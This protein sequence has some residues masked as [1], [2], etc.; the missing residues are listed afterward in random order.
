MRKLL[1]AVSLYQIVSSLISLVIFERAVIGFFST[2]QLNWI[3]YL[4]TLALIVAGIFIIYSN[5]LL[6]TSCTKS[7]RLIRWNK[8]INFIQ[9]FQLSIFGFTYQ[10]VIGLEI[11]LHMV[12]SDKIYFG[13]H[14]ASFNMKFI[15]F[16]ESGVS[17]WMVGVNVI[18]LLIFLFFD[19][20]ARSIPK[21][22][23]SNNLAA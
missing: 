17:F 9:I 14:T 2:N 7:K 8:W 22:I 10:F 4:S 21:T 6:L 15:I 12:Y 18:P 19:S 3:L 13:L 23:V 1:I 11:L 5:I 16:F 20:L